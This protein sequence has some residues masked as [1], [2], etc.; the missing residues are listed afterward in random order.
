MIGLSRALDLILTERKVRA[1]EAYIV[2]MVNRVAPPGDA[3]NAAIQ[4]AKCLSIFPQSA[5][6]NGRVFNSFQQ[7]MRNESMYTFKDLIDEIQ[8]KKRKVIGLN[9]AHGL[10]G[11]KNKILIQPKEKVNFTSKNGHQSP[12]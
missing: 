7:D 3:L 8:E 9:G 4:L 1:E 10:K 5:L 11:A 12:K 2:G 6:N